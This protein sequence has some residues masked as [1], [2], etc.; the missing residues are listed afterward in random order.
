[1]GGELENQTRPAEDTLANKVVGNDDWSKAQTFVN[2][3][4]TAPARQS[5]DPGAYSRNRPGSPEPGRSR[6]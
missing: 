6:I 1:L 5:P 3:T 2:G 4:A